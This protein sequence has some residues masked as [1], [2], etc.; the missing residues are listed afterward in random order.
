MEAVLSKRR[1][2]LRW[3]ELTDGTKWQQGIAANWKPCSP[4]TVAEGGW[5]GFSAVAKFVDKLTGSHALLLFSRFS[6]EVDFAIDIKTKRAAFKLEANGH[7]LVCL[8]R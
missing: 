5:S 8:Y 4:Q 2:I 3:E 7:H 1:F 6:D